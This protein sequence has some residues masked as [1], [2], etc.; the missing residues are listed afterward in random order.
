MGRAVDF[1][2]EALGYR[3]QVGGAAERWSELAPAGG[4]GTVLAL[5]HSDS[6]AEAHPRVHLDLVAADAAE[7]AAEIQRIVRLGAQRVDWDRYPANPDFVV[8]AD[9]DGNCFCV[10]DASHE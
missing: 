10:V 1:W 3:V 8:L 4:P 7:Q 6:P 9:P 5:Q 2:C